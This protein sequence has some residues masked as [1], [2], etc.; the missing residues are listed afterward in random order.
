MISNNDTSEK[1]LTISQKNVAEQLTT[2]L[3]EKL[4]LK[5]NEVTVV[6]VLQL[7]LQ[8]INALYVENFIRYCRYNEISDQQIETD[9]K[10]FIEEQ[11]IN[12]KKVIKK[13]LEFSQI[14]H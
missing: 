8:L 11:S 7:I 12:T 2:E 3:M 6:G 13:I 4:N 1:T 5:S 9:I 10:N 14:K